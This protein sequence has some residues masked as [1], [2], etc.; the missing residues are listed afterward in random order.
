MICIQEAKLVEP[1]QRIM[2]STG[3][4][5]V[6]KWCNMNAISSSGGILGRWQIKN[7]L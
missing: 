3:E 2:N 1:T 4:S 7:C 6:D 5:Y